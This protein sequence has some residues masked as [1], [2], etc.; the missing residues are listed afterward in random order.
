[1]LDKILGKVTNAVILLMTC[2]FIAS[3]CFV[4]ERI[5][6]SEIKAK[7]TFASKENV[8]SLSRD[9]QDIKEQQKK[10]HDVLIEIRTI[11]KGVK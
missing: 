7:D 8:E 5:N 3:P 9:V 6:A 2:G 4:W 10:D 11:V 1:M